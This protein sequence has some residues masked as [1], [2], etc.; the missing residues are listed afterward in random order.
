MLREL[1]AGIAIMD[2]KIIRCRRMPM[3]VTLSGECRVAMLRSLRNEMNKRIL[4]LLAASVCLPATAGAIDHP[5]AKEGLWQ[6]HT[7]TTDNPGAR[8]SEGTVKV[9]RSHAFD[10]A[11]EAKNKERKDCQTLEEN[12]SGDTYTSSARCSVANTT[13]ETKGTT[14]FG[15]NA[16]HSEIHVTYTPALYGNSEETMIQ[17]QTFLGACPAGMQPGDRQAQDGRI[18]HRQ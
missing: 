4:M 14:K 2:H 11:V 16:S 18:I 1:P 10:A 8:F 17:D 3:R 6:I 9:C 5:P 7:Q 15:D 12:L 13:I